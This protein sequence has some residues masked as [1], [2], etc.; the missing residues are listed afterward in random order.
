MLLLDQRNIFGPK[1]QT[2]FC[3]LYDLALKWPRTIPM[4]KRILKRFGLACEFEPLWNWEQSSLELRSA[5]LGLSNRKSVGPSHLS[6]QITNVWDEASNDYKMDSL[7]KFYRL[8]LGKAKTVP[9]LFSSAN[10]G[11]LP[12]VK[13]C[14]FLLSRNNVIVA[15]V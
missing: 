13:Y 9:P 11:F 5:D 10:V 12:V 1:T 14:W 4:M 3:L 2:S 8:G 6:S 7:L 15:K